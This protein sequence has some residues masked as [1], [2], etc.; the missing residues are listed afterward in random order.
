MIPTHNRPQQVKEAV[1]SVLD[2]TYQDFEIIVVDDGLEQRAKGV[3]ASFDNE[4]IRYIQHKRN[5]GG[6]AARNTGIKSARGEWIAF[7]D[8]DDKWVPKKLEVQMEALKDVPDDVGF[9]FSAVLKKMENANQRTYIKPAGLHNYHLL[10]LT[11]F[12]GFLT[13]TLLVYKKVFDQVGGFDESLPSN[14]EAELIIRITKKWRGVGI[15][16]PLVTQN[17]RANHNSIGSSL[18]RRIAG[19]ETVLEKHREEFKLYPRIYAKHL[20]QLGIWCRDSEKYTKAKEYFWKAFLK[21][22]KTK[23]LLH[24]LSMIRK[25]VFFRIFIKPFR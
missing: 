12:K 23:Y 3:I 15:N 21:I 13:S 24:T 1:Q 8:D 5:R 19:R 20:F 17:V 11:R 22:K 2:Q 25:G 6:G 14:Q 10:S 7:L 4:R 9:C 16:D 18:K